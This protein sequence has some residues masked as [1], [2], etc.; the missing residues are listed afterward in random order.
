VA[1]G[2]DGK[3]YKLDGTSMAVPFVTGSLALI[4]SELPQYQHE[5]NS[6]EADINEIKEKI[7]STAKKLPNQETPHDDRYG[8]GLFQA[9]DFY[10]ALKDD[11][12]RPTIFIGH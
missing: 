5:N 6:G 10:R 7:K 8:Y 2:L 11:C 12:S 1:P 9:Y 4:L 3:Y